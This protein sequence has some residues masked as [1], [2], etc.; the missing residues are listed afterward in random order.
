[1]NTVPFAKSA[2][3]EAL[4]AAL[5]GEIAA[6]LNAA[7]QAQETASHEGNKPENQYDTLALEAAYLAHGQSE[8][9]RE[10]Q[11][12]R[13]LIGQWPVPDFSEDDPI[14]S[15]ALIQLLD[16]QNNSAQQNQRWLWIA[17][18]G[19]RQLVAEGRTIAV[20]STQAPLAQTLMRLSIGD[21]VVMGK[22]R[23]EI[24]GVW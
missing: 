9:I 2:L 20:L 14:A 15:G 13:I 6:A 1:L 24:G 11:E 19:G 12:T 7:R 23:W 21:E 3:K 8:R 22:E 17:P 10:L 16:T 5:D 18:V 4:L